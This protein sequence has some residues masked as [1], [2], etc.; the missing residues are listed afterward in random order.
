MRTHLICGCAL[1]GSYL[2]EDHRPKGGAKPESRRHPDLP[3]VPYR[4]RHSGN[5]AKEAAKFARS[6]SS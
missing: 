1:D 3:H 6:T 2:C 5:P 4:S